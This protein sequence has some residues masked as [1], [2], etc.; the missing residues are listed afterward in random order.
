MIYTFIAYAP[1]EHNKDL[2]WI[3]NRYV[4]IVPNDDDWICFIDH[5]AMF[6]TPGWYKHL[7]AVI[8]DNPEY[9]LFTAKTNRVG[10]KRQVTDLIGPHNH[11]VI[12]HRKIGYELWY[13]NKTKIT[14]V[15]RSHPIS[16]VVMLF[17]KSSW[18]KTGGYPEGEFFGCDNHFHN[19]M[20]AAG[21][22]TGIMEGIYVYHWWRDRKP[23]FVRLEKQL[24]NG[25]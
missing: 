24:K 12:A 15:S 13:K 11:D 20:K 14:D 3:Y 17:Q 10:N 21:L 5:D 8:N 16:G 4:E 1:Q 25:A 18:R 6:T 19:R 2:G 22:K 7:V 23:E 9:S